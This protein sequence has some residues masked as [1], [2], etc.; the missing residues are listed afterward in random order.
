MPSCRV[1]RQ[2]RGPIVD[3]L[4]I[5]VGTHDGPAKPSGSVRGIV[6][7][8]VFLRLVAS[9]LAQQFAKKV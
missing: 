2:G 4:S 3:S 8:N 1:L 7:S 9:T 5:A 6:V